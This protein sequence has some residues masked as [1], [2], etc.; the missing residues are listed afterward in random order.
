MVNTKREEGP[1]PYLHVN[2]LLATNPS[3]QDEVKISEFGPSPSN[4]ISQPALIPPISTIDRTA[5]G[6]CEWINPNYTGSNPASISTSPIG[7]QKFSNFDDTARTP[8][9]SILKVEYSYKMLKKLEAMREEL[10]GSNVDNNE[11]V[12]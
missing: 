8:R 2:T 4:V 1:N 10:Y 12:D 6:V 11:P 7:G 9:G 3:L 5:T